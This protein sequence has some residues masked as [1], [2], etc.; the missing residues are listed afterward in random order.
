MTHIYKTRYAK[1]LLARL[2]VKNFGDEPNVRGG[3]N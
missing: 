2:S 1:P 3:A